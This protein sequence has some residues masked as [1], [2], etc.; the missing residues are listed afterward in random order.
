MSEQVGF[1]FISAPTYRQ[2]ARHEFVLRKVQEHGDKFR[3]L[4]IDWLQKNWPIWEAFDAQA[5]RVWLAGRRH[6]GA[7]RIG[8]FLRYESALREVDS[9]GFKCNDHLWPDAARLYVILNPERA[10]LF[11]F[12]GRPS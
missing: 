7:R 9:D 11:E 8:E 10:D 12:R 4:D 5:T 2:L 3:Y 1:D 6:F